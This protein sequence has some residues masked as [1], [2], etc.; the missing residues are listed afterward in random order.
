MKQNLIRLAF[1]ILNVIAIILLSVLLT[2]NT[3]DTRDYKYE[4]YCDSIYDANPN[5]YFDVLVETDSFQNY[6]D[7]H[8]EWWNK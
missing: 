8:G 2:S 6:I 3:D 5:Y 4:S 1:I 7:K